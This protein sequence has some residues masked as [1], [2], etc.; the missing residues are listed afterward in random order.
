[1]TEPRAEHV[2]ATVHE[3]LTADA[4]LS[5]NKRSLQAGSHINMRRVFPLHVTCESCVPSKSPYMA[6]AQCLVQQAFLRQLT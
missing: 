2:D 4:G 5:N 3:S 6:Y 1:M